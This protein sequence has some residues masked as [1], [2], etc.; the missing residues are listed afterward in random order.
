MFGHTFVG[1]HLT[2]LKVHPGAPGFLDLV[3]VVAQLVAAVL[4]A[5]EA[6]ALVKRFFGAAAV[7]QALLILIHKGVDEQVHRALMRTFHQLV[8]VC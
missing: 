3:D 6:Q 4:A 8:H 7:S 1:H 5:A 2:C